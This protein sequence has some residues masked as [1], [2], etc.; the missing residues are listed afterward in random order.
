[1]ARSPSRPR[2]TAP[3]ARVRDWLPVLFGS[4]LPLLAVAFLP[5]LEQPGHLPRELLVLAGGP[6]ALALALRSGG[7]APHP[8]LAPLL[9]LPGLVAL[10]GIAL[11]PPPE[12]FAV[13]REVWLAAC[14]A[15]IAWAAAS[16]PAEEE[17]ID[18]WLERGALAA[19]VP[20]AVIGLAQA[21]FSWDG[22]PQ[23]RPPASTF[24]NRNVA[25]QTVVALLP[26]AATALAARGL[27]ARVGSAVVAA[28]GGVYLLAS[29]TRGAWLA[30]LGAWGLA[31]V[32]AAIARRRRNGAGIWLPRRALAAASGVLAVVALAAAIP[33]RDQEGRRMPGLRVYAESLANPTAGTGVVRLALWRNSLA[34]LEG[35]PWLGVGRGRFVV[36][37]P[38]FHET[39]ARTPAFGLDVQAEHAHSDPLELAVELGLPAS[40]LLLVLLCGAAARLF[41]EPLALGSPARPRRLAQG[42][43]LAALLLHGLVSFPLHSPATAAVAAILAG[44]GWAPRGAAARRSPAAKAVTVAVLLAAGGGALLGL[45]ELTAQRQ[46]GRALEAH[47]AGR[48]TEAVRAA[49]AATER[50]PWQRRTRGMAAVIHRDCE[51]DPA[52]SLELLEPALAMHPHQVNLLLATG[53]RRLKAERAEQ[54][55]A[56][57]EHAVELHPRLANA[58]VGLA[59]ARDRLGDAA[60][61]AAACSEALRL[62]PDLAAARAFCGGERP[63]GAAPAPPASPWGS[64]RP[65][66]R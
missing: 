64:S 51:P 20:L 36:E 63:D 41:A 44:R 18:R 57:F 55:L 47:A 33:V 21:W 65:R 25:A 2:H 58:W 56:A 27:L 50:A 10:A 37:Y 11:A 19:L 39:R 45:A 35:A 24:V 46:L 4:S 66:Q 61:A 16:R 23:A 14:L 30:A 60:G 59:M 42:A 7:V 49:L 3:S 13:A 29:R 22:L 9:A 17:A 26:L 15:A 53:A 1:M 48:C 38:R 52:R 28:A 31:V 32:V 40:L 6:L 8:A 54:A 12:R 5:G 62:A 43:A 34:L